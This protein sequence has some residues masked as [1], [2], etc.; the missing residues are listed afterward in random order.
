MTLYNDSYI[1]R[2][3]PVSNP[4]A[5]IIAIRAAQNTRRWGY[6]AAMR[7]CRNRGVV[8]SVLEAALW[9]HVNK[10]NPQADY[11]DCITFKDY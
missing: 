7:Y 9:C 11:K 3:L 8:E 2:E 6:D 1:V 5:V 4:A 10:D